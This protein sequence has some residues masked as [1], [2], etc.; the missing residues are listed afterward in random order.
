MADVAFGSEAQSVGSE[1]EVVSVVSRI[2][3]A[4]APVL[5]NGGSTSF[6]KLSLQGAS[7]GMPERKG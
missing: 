6:T 7:A 3:L 4:C 2:C 1:F 5:P